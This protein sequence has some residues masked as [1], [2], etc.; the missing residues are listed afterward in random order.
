MLRKVNY[1]VN[2]M[3]YDDE[4]V[5]VTIMKLVMIMTGDA[6][7]YHENYDDLDGNDDYF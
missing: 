2:I 7:M 6:M 5:L 4:E 1:F 3:F